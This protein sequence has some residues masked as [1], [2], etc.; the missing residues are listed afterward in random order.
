VG[1]YLAAWRDQSSGAA[2]EKYV[3]EKTYIDAYCADYKDVDPVKRESC[4]DVAW[5][6]SDKP[7][8]STVTQHSAYRASAALN[9]RYSQTMRSNTY[10]GV[11]RADL[12]RVGTDDYWYLHGQDRLALPADEITLRRKALVQAIID[13]IVS[14]TG[15]KVA[16]WAPHV[17][18]TEGVVLL[19]AVRT[20]PFVSPILVDLDDDE[21]P[22]R[23]NSNYTALVQALANGTDTW[24]WEF[25]NG[26]ELIA[27]GG[28][29]AQKLEAAA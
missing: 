4:F 10:A 26:S 5:L 8:S 13:L 17:F 19:S 25:S 27:A 20:A 3:A 28:E 12:H 23:A 2:P 29:I 14:P 18:C 22:I 24:T 15:A 11:I 9:S 16:A 7:Q 21:Q 6:I 1:G